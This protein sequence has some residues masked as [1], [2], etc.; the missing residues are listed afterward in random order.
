M[1]IYFSG[2]G[3]RA[4]LA[5]TGTHYHTYWLTYDATVS[6]MEEGGL[7]LEHVM[8]YVDDI[9]A[10]RKLVILDH[11]HSGTVEP[12]KPG[13][14]AAGGGGAAAGVRDGAAGEP[15]IAK[16]LFLPQL[17]GEV[18]GVA[19]GRVKDAL[20]ILGSAADPKAYEVESLK[21]GIFTSAL[22]EALTTTNADARKAGGNENG[23]LS[24]EELVS[25]LD[26][27]V[28]KL[29]QDNSLVQVP[30]KVLQGEVF[31]WQLMPLPQDP[32]KEAD[33]LL[34]L[35]GRLAASGLD[36]TVEQVL[37]IG[38]NNWAGALRNKVPPAD[39]DLRIVQRLQGILALG[40]AVNW[41][42]EARKLTGFVEGLNRP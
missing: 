27:Q 3:L 28:V 1:L 24:A 36:S 14:P 18:L 39:R 11:C 20:L 8:D 37:S 13:A 35:L 9:P 15:E 34:A 5:K 12:P 2:H 10:S 25:Y 40:A 4:K 31:G 7:R 30:I 6:Q 33:G 41:T 22:L 21:H 29:A 26:V 32:G 23:Q 16:D 42:S 19:T 38:D 17:P